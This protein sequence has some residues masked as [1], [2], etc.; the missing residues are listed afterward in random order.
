MARRRGTTVARDLVEDPNYAVDLADSALLFAMMNLSGADAG[1][2]CWNDKYYWDFWRPWQ[3]IH[4]A[5]RDDNP[6]TEPDGVLDGA[7]DRALSRAPVGASLPR[8]RNLAGA[9]DV[10]RHGQD[11]VRRDEQPLRR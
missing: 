2:N 9:A 6:A 4:E 3:A 11:R 7:P 1:I 10:L 8:R 5:D